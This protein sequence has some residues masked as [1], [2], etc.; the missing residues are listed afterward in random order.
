MATSRTT[1]GEDGVDDSQSLSE[2]QFQSQHYHPPFKYSQM[3]SNKLID[4]AISVDAEAAENQRQTALA[5]TSSTL[6]EVEAD[7][8]PVSTFTFANAVPYANQDEDDEDDYEDEDEL[9]RGE[10]RAVVTFL[11]NG[12]SMGSSQS[13]VDESSGSGHNSI[14]SERNLSE[15]QEGSKREVPGN[16][17]AGL[18][19]GSGVL[20]VFSSPCREYFPSS[21]ISN[22]TELPEYVQMMMEKDLALKRLVKT[23]SVT[24]SQVQEE[25]RSEDEEK[26]LGDEDYLY[27]DYALEEKSQEELLKPFAPLGN[28]DDW[29]AYKYPYAKRLL[30]LAHMS[31]SVS[32][33]NASSPSRSE[34]TTVST[35]EIKTKKTTSKKPQLTTTTTN[36]KKITS[37]LPKSSSGGPRITPSPKRSFKTEPQQQLSVKNFPIP[38]NHSRLSL[39]PTGVT[40]S[41]N[42]KTVD[43]SK[44]NRR[45]RN[46]KAITSIH[47]SGSDGEDPLSSFLQVDPTKF[48]E[49][50]VLS[51]AFQLLDFSN[52]FFFFATYRYPFKKVN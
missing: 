48:L 42:G 5:A 15:A 45:Q 1:G 17:S 8:T 41:Q 9:S 51:I 31:I 47:N 13:R 34:N 16:R 36:D 29:D 38:N 40:T 50:R 46:R 23:G 14:M 4:L 44:T 26:Y 7:K 12:K 6:G 24:I 11:Q 33:S 28:I 18:Q 3:F 10:E 30:E 20:T 35:G 39:S 43:N 22:H 52:C 32:S 25:A 19:R 37:T 49:V 21:K 2:S 27:D